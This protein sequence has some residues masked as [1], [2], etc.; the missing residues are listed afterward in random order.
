MNSVTII[1]IVVVALLTLLIGGL[2]WLAYSSCIRA[3][4]TEVNQGS[5][6]EEI[7]KEHRH[8]K[9]K[10]S[11]LGPICSC[12]IL[13]MLLGLFTSGAVYK[14]SGNNFT[15]NNHTAL[16]CKSGSMS[17]FYNDSIAQE[18]DNDRHL[19]F[20]VGDICI[21]EKISNDD[22]LVEGEVYGYKYKNIIITH[23]LVSFNDELNTC[24]FRGDNN[25]TFD[26]AVQRDNVIYHYTGTK[27]PGVGTFILFA[28]SYF[29]I[30]CICCVIFIAVS[31]EI[32]YHK[33]DKINKE[34]IK[35]LMTYEEV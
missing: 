22:T 11:K 17:D 31:S 9:S 30:W 13:L 15:I 34:R 33:I 5:H 7:K 32:V 35:E 24:K 1:T 6:D 25:P 14:A 3:Y 19:Q 29:G 8:K 18:L 2:T 4:R 27:I 21:F 20:D 12:T 10:K 28:Q 26:G 16:V 23:R